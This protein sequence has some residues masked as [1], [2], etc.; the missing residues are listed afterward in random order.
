MKR[1]ISIAA[2]MISAHAL[3]DDA[4]AGAP[5]AAAM[6]T[7]KKGTH[8][9]ALDDNGVVMEHDSEGNAIKCQTELR[10]KLKE[11]KCEG[12]KKLVYK[13]VGEALGKEMKPTPLTVT[14]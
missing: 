2:L 1:L 3:A 6:P 8:C 7:K 9:R 4:D 12:G 5:A 14:C 13:F 11:A 10:E